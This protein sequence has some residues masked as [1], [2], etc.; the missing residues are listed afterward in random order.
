MKSYLLKTFKKPELNIVDG[1]CSSGYE[2]YTLAMMFEN[3]GKKVNITAFDLGEEAI[4]DAKAGEFGIKKI[5]NDYYDAM[6]SEMISGFSDN[7]LAFPSPKKLSEKQ[8][9]YKRLFSEFFTE[10]PYEEKFSFSE[11]LKKVLLPK[12]FQCPILTKMFKI[13]P[14]KADTCKFLQGDIL[15]LDEIVPEKSADVLLFRN[16]LYHLTTREGAMSMKIQLPEEQVVPVVKQVINQVDKAVAPNGLFVLGEHTSDHVGVA[17]STLYTELYK[18]DFSPVYFNSDGS[19]YLIW[20][21]S[22]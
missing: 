22:K 13:K 16:A 9:E 2:P 20:K 4:R 11:W 17:G 19:M 14:E 18:H 21:K 8:Q 1:A 3:S 7:Y 10:I 15:K 5:G 12:R 6:Y